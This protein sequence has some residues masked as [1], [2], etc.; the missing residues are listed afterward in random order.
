MVVQK[1][2]KKL[3]GDETWSAHGKDQRDAVHSRQGES[4]RGQPQS[5]ELSG[6]YLEYQCKEKI[7]SKTEVKQLGQGTIQGR[8][9]GKGK[10]QW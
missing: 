10:E 3:L 1:I 8:L 2:K 4:C 5:L 6:F 9:W 7:K